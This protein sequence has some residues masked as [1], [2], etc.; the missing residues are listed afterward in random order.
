M[1]WSISLTVGLAILS[2]IN[3]W[4]ISKRRETFIVDNK[5][6]DQ[7]SQLEKDVVRM[8]EQIKGTEKDLTSIGSKLDNFNTKL[9]ELLGMKALLEEV[10]LSVRELRRYNHQTSPLS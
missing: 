9:S 2:L 4:L 10:N 5:Q 3:A 8:A 7:I 1:I 6:T